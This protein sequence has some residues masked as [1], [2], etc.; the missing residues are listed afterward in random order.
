MDKEHATAYAILKAIFAHLYLV[1]I[2]PFGDG[3]GRTARLLEF[4]ILTAA[5]LPYPVTH[6]LSNYSQYPHS[7]RLFS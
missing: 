6:L 5:S 7:T 3:N 4:H 1:W 2:H